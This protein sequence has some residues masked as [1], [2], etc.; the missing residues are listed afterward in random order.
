[1]RIVI[2]ISALLLSVAPAW[3]QQQQ[4]DAV[5]LAPL[6]QQQRNNAL[7]GMAS[8]AAL[9][10]DLQA[11]LAELEKKIADATKDTK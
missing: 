2:V 4:S 5:R 1:M 9:V 7:D 6:Y 11:R 8:C 3:S 10:A